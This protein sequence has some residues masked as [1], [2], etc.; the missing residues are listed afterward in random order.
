MTD[1]NH[2]TTN[3]KMTNTKTTN[4]KS[5]NH[6]IIRIY[7]TDRLIKQSCNEFIVNYPLI[8]LYK[9]KDG[10][11]NYIDSLNNTL[12][13]IQP[14]IN[15]SVSQN[16]NSIQ[17]LFDLF[18]KTDYIS[19]IMQCPWDNALSSLIVSIYSPEY[20]LFSLS[21]KDINI[22][23]NNL[24]LVSCTTL[25]YPAKQELLKDIYKIIASQYQVSPYMFCNLFL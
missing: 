16:E 15:E 3:C 9:T 1:K 6:K 22:I 2:K 13:L 18:S 7:K 20:Y 8:K 23:L 11:N 17:L 5:I 12:K 21:D 24:H 10:M 4:C 25:K 14:D 19:A